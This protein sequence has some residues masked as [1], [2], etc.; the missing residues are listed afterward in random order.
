MTYFADLTPY[1][2]F[3]SNKPPRLN[4][5]WL[6]AAHEFETGSIEPG[7]FARLEQICR[8]SVNQTRGIHICNICSAPSSL[9]Y[10]LDDRKLL[11]GSAEIRVF[12]PEA[13]IF[14]APTLLLH[15][16]KDHHYLPPPSFLRAL[17]NGPIPPMQDYFDFL[18]E[19]CTD[20]NETCIT[21]GRL[22]FRPPTPPPSWMT[23]RKVVD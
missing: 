10:D 15:Y 13:D 11:L 9:V 6:D 12:S 8:Y 19:Q 14:A 18:T 7:T 4:V 17:E 2:Y 23:N 1:N 5:G 3:R 20:W 21:D 22:E 16:I